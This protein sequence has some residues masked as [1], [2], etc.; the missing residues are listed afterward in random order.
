MFPDFIGLDFVRICAC[1]QAT[2]STNV[3]FCLLSY[4]LVR[5]LR[6]MN[7]ANQPKASLNLSINSEI[8]RLM[9]I[10][11]AVEG[12]DVSTVTEKLYARYLKMRKK[13][14]M[15]TLLPLAILAFSSCAIPGTSPRVAQYQQDTETFRQQL[16]AK[17]GPESQWTPAQSSYY[18]SHATA[19]ADAITA[20]DQAGIN[21]IET[22]RQPN[23][24]GT[25]TIFYSDGTIQIVRPDGHG[26]YVV[27]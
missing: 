17:W 13:V 27:F 23:Q 11:C 9:K 16:V 19:G 14:Q 20:S 7:E 5:I 18:I 26:G 1:A 10:Q 15:K 24:D 21:T 22:H 8:K 2:N 3:D 12:T 25:V 4:A 6:I